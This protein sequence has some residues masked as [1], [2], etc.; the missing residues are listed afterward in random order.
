MR[1]AGRVQ[2]GQELPDLC[3]VA[4][5]RQGCA[6]GKPDSVGAVDTGMRQVRP[7]GIVGRLEQGLGRGVAGQ[8]GSPPPIPR[9][10]LADSQK[11]VAIAEMSDG[12]FW[13]DTGDVIITLG[14]CLEDPV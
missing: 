11:V 2:R 5:L 13:Q 8:A 14:A 3:H 1:R 4:S 7:A 10:K 12:S 6:D 9:I